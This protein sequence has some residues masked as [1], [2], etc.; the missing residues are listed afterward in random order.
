MPVSD[1]RPACLACGKVLAVRQQAI[2][3][4]SVPALRPRGSTKVRLTTRLVSA[5]RVRSGTYQTLICIDIYS[6]IRRFT[7][8]R[9]CSSGARLTIATSSHSTA[10]GPVPNTIIRTGVASLSKRST[11]VIRFVSTVA[12]STFEC[13]LD[14]APWLP[15][16]SPQRYAALVDG[17]HAFDVRAISASGAADLTPAHISWTV[18]RVAPAVTVS[19][20][21]SG[22]TTHENKPA[23]SGR[24]ARRREI[25]RKSRL[26]SSLDRASRVCPSRR[27]RRPLRAE[28]GRW[29]R[30]G[31]WRTAH[32]LRERSSPTAQA[33]RA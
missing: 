21:M 32:T 23:F 30:P 18:R 24:L 28:P 22:S 5:L 25:P 17:P 6:Q 2:R 20:P 4:F 29:H 15:C 8:H 19:S 14:G 31:R 7:Q 3:T 10:S 12:A 33:P 26:R 11:A 13:S 27:W 9:N 16:K 1:R